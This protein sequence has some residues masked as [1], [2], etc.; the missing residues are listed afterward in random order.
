MTSTVNLPSVE[1]KA[2]ELCEF[3]VSQDGYQEARNRVEAFMEDDGAKDLYRAWQ[4]K[5]AEMHHR[6]HQ[7]IEPGAPDVEE[8]ER[9][10]GEVMGNQ[11]AMGFVNAE[12]EMNQIFET[13]TTLLQK[14]LQLGHV[15]TAEELKASECCNS[16]G[17]GCG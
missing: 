17:C 6:S 1:E 7:G 14:S 16:G 15:P 10:K 8:L 11:A 12:G 2:R 9:L 3:V 4:E 5:G 13:V